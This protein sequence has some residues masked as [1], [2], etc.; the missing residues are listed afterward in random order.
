MR[1]AYL[2]EIEEFVAR[3]RN[4]CS[5]GDVDCVTV[6]TDQPPDRV[7]IKFLAARSRR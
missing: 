7:L 3:V 1:E 6:T 2:E 5:E 4:A